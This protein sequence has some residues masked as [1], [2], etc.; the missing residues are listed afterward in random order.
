ME[1]STEINVLRTIDLICCMVFASFKPILSKAASSCQK[2][3]L[4]ESMP[5]PSSSEQSL[6]FTNF[7]VFFLL[8]LKFVRWTNF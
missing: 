8:I 7:E 2:S 1:G 5:S 6:F 4:D 3:H